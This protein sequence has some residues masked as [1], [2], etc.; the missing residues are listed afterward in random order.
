MT[1]PTQERTSKLY[2]ADPGSAF[3]VTIA[4]GIVLAA[5]GTWFLVGVLMG[6]IGA[7]ILAVATAGQLALL[8]VPAALLVMAQRGPRALGFRSPP[9]PMMIAAVLIGCSAWLLN[10]QLVRLFPITEHTHGALL[11]AVIQPPLIWTLIVVAGLPAICEEV[12]FRGVLTRGLA[13]RFSAPVAVIIS[14]VVFGLYHMSVVQFFSTFTLGL[15]LGALTLRSGSIVPG[16]VT[17]LINNATAVLVSRSEVP[18]LSGWID[19]NL[20][21]ALLSATAASAL[22]IVILIKSGTKPAV[23]AAR[24]VER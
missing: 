24:V 19:D 4:V 9:W 23:A 6:L 10:L 8:V 1:I 5:L 12:L 16:M 22:G 13:T 14:S 20:P 21:V 17:H 7:P 3:S 15:A 11:N 18:P 2:H